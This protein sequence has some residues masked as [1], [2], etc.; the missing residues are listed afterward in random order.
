[1]DTEKRWSQ[2]EAITFCRVLE[3][4]SPK[5][6][7]HI[8]LTG[9]CLYRDGPRKDLDILV[10]RIRQA[11]SIDWHGFFNECKTYGIELIHDYGWCKKATW[12]GKDIDIFDPEDKSD[13]EYGSEGSDLECIDIFKDIPI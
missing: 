12:K 9:G 1:M 5:Y 6:G 11:E 7:A 13:F 10:Y 2:V 4:F 3:T 8:S